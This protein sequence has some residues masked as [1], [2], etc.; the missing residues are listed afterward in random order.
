MKASTDG[1]FFEE[2]GAT[3]GVLCD[4][5]TPYDQMMDGGR[6]VTGTL[7]LKY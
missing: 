4:D 2:D 3:S 1:G 5:S 6:V 7:L